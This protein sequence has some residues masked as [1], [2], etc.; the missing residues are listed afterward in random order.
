[1][2]SELF[3]IVAPVFLT[4]AIGFAWVRSGRVFD[5][6]FVTGIVLTIATPCLVFSSLT[7]L[8]VSLETLGAVAG[9]YL[10]VLVL[11]GLVGAVVIKYALRLPLPS[12]LPSVMFGNLGNMGIPLAF[13]AFGDTG[14][15][16]AVAAFSV[17]SVAQFTV[18]ISIHA[19][20]V[21]AKQ[22][23]RTP[24]LYGLLFS[25][26]FMF[27]QTALPAWAT[28]TVDLLASLVVPL[29]LLTLGVS[30]AR[31]RLRRV[32]RSLGFA[33]GRL[34]GGFVAGILVAEIFDLEGVVKGVLILQSTMPVAIFNYVF[35]LR[36]KREPDDVAAAIILSTAISFATMPFLLVFVL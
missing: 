32:H 35:A 3:S 4:A 7:R 22:L 29:M 21:H 20:G 13:F 31:M 28:N 12:Y 23:V 26:P 19:G 9:S 24:V 17:H 10:S 14:L 25:L 27:T 5:T 1:M 16:L 11:V 2:T 30:L 15:A 33:V 36:Y 18:G 6:D 34:L 8:D